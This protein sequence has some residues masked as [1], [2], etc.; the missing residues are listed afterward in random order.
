M[1]ERVHQVGL[2][3][4]TVMLPTS[5]VIRR[6]TKR[7]TITLWPLLLAKNPL[8]NHSVLKSLQHEGKRPHSLEIRLLQ[9]SF[10]RMNGRGVSLFRSSI[11]RVLEAVHTAENYYSSLLRS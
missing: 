7:A 11:L 5:I 10:L 1:F 8:Q 3:T 4:I 2:A 6:L 9:N